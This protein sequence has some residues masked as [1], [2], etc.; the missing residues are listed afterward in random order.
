[1]TDQPDPKHQTPP[2]REDVSPLRPQR[3]QGFELPDEDTTQAAASERWAT[4][5]N[6]PSER[7]RVIRD[8]MESVANEYAERKIS[9]AQFNAIYA[10]YSEQRTIIERIVAKDPHS[11]GWKQAGR[12]GKTSFLRAH[13][14]ARPTN[15]VIF[16]HK[17]PRP[18]MGGGTRPDMERIQGLLKALWGIDTVRVGVARLALK[19][20]KW[21][22]MAAGQY[23]VTF[24][25]F[26]LEPSGQQATYVNDLHRDFERANQIYLQRGQ[27]IRSQMVFP[28]RA[29]LENRIDD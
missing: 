9:R 18:L 17:Q 24:V 1:M 11:D 6:S 10:H 19:A 7:L 29:L 21:L 16:L 26:H 15:Y 5:P 25:T 3:P 13:F 2:D 20:P 14:E 28:Q 12:S 4:E 27:I 23:S 8:K 22:I